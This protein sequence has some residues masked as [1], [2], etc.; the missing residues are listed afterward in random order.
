MKEGLPKINKSLLQNTIMKNLGSSN[1]HLG[2]KFLKTSSINP[3][4]IRKV[5]LLEFRL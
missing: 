1:S 4:I 2:E 5:E 3:D